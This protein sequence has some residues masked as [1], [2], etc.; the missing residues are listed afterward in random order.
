MKREPF[1]TTFANVAQRESV[2]CGLIRA[3]A[4]EVAG[5]IPAVRFNQFVEVTEKAH[6]P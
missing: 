2:V 1:S 4:T 5:S 6:G 3:A